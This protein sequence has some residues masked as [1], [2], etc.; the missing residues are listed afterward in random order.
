MPKLVWRVR[1]VAEL[2]PG[3]T[4]KTEVARIERD[5]EAGFAELGLRLEEV[6]RLAAALQ[7]EIVTA[8]VAT[9]GERRRRWCAACGQMLACKGHYRA[10]FRSLFGDVP[11]RALRPLAWPCQGSAGPK[12]LAAL[13]LGGGA[14]A[15]ELAYVTARY[16]ALAPFGKVAA[17]LSELLPLG[18]AANAGTVRNRTRRVGEG[19]VQP[20]AIETAK[21]PAVRAGGPVVVGLD[22]GH[23][24]G[25]RPEEGRHFEVVA[26]K[27]I[28]SDGIQHRFAFARNG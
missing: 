13:D 26:G 6:K 28:T 15:P 12:S 2:G 27:V 20:Y 5:K 3:V 17:L 21:R 8:Q 4:T 24:R 22:G 11:V 7:A 10:T 18:G 1:L 16:A 23:V 19:V 25:R 9:A 14:V